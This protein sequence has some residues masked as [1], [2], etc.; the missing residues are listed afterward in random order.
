MGDIV[1]IDDMLASKLVSSTTPV[2]IVWSLIMFI[3]SADKE[4]LETINNISK[5]LSYFTG[6][7][8]TYVIF[9]G[10][11]ILGITIYGFFL[12]GF[13]APIKGLSF[14]TVVLISVGIIMRS[15]VKPYLKPYSWVHKYS[16]YFAWVYAILAVVS[17]SFSI[18]YEPIQLLLLLEDAYE[19]Y[20]S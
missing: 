20:G 12:E 14:F 1:G 15:S 13:S 3:Y 16:I 6:A 11:V 5:H 10:G 8:G 17:Y 9:I 7:T 2:F 19:Q 18:L 4:K